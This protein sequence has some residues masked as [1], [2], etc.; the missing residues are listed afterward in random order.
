MT[1]AIDESRYSPFGGK[2]LVFPLAAIDT[3]QL[4]CGYRYIFVAAIST[5]AAEGVPLFGFD[6]LEAVI[7]LRTGRLFDRGAGKV[8]ER[9]TIT[10]P[11]AYA[12]ATVTLIF[13]PEDD[14]RSFE[15]AGSAI[16]SISGSIVPI[17]MGAGASVFPG[18]PFNF[19]LVDTTGGD[20]SVV[21]PA[22]VP[23]IIGGL[24]REQRLTVKAK[25]PGVV[26]VTVAAGGATQLIDGA[27][28]VVLLAG[29]CLEVVAVSGE[30]RIL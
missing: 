6:G 9:I 24:T 23:H 26:T 4:P 27:A 3:K 19:A 8:F 21:L 25:G 22:T 17:L 14:F 16:G 7:P 11:I 13:S 10:N 28:S 1:N 30:Y 18:D 5:V 12:G 2:P 20:A 29:A 15:A